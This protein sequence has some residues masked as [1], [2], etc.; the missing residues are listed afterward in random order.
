MTHLDEG[1]LLAVRDGESQHEHLVECADCRKGLAE[2]RGRHDRVSGALAAL[3]APTDL[4][5]ARALIRTRVTAGAAHTA[6]VVPLTIPPR[7]AFWSLSRAAGL[8][9]VTAAGLSALPGS[10]VRHW[11]SRVLAPEAPR[12][13]TERAP[14]PASAPSSAEAE[15][16]G[17]RLAVPR[18]P[19]RV[20]VGG[21]ETGAVI[22][23]QWVPGAEA[24][25]F[26]PAG[27]RFTSGEGRLEAQVT[28]GTV[29]IELPR[30]VLP[31]SLEVGG[32]IYLRSTD[33]GL[34][35]PGPVTR[36]STSEIVFRIP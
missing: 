13:G 27:S 7:R 24:A 9:L 23:V 26:A 10:P 30:G 21:A 19:L 17:I 18:G 29:R 22:R 3:D 35:V 14:T 28:S 25:I 8:L 15:A 32:R 16:T 31:V 20:I 33:A 12:Q 11:A 34:D 5:V 1:Q 6:D 4:E 36:Q 2:L